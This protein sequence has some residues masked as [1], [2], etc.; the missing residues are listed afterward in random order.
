MLSDGWD[1]HG[2]L[3]HVGQALPF[4]APEFPGVFVVPYVFID[5]VKGGYVASSLFNEKD[6]YY[7][8]LP[9]R[10][11]DF[12]SPGALAGEGVR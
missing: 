7:E 5:L 1:A 9:R 12:F 4:S 10:P 3:W 11:E 8:A 6:R 2:K